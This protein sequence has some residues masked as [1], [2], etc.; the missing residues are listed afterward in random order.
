MHYA[1]VECRDRCIKLPIFVDTGGQIACLNEISWKELAPSVDVTCWGKTRSMLG[2]I[3][4]VEAQIHFGQGHT[5]GVNMV[6]DQWLCKAGLILI[7]DY[8]GLGCVLIR[9]SDEALK[10]LPLLPHVTQ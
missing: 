4:G 3:H 6:G 5:K 7:A 9:S 10:T 1:A 2:K 8:R